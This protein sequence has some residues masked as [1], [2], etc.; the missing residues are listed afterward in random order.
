ML[1][2]VDDEA[3]EADGYHSEDIDGDGSHTIFLCAKLVVDD[4]QNFD[5]EN[6]DIIRVIEEDSIEWF[7]LVPRPEPETPN[8]V[9]ATLEDPK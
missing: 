9:S 6:S 5:R 8:V 7:G 4:N 3:I 2:Y 1:Y